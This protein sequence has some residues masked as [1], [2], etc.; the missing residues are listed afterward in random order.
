MLLH[1]GCCWSPDCTDEGEGCT[2]TRSSDNICEALSGSEL[3]LVEATT[4]TSITCN[5]D[6]LQCV[7]GVLT[8]VDVVRGNASVGDEIPY[9]L[10]IEVNGQHNA[11]W[12]CRPGASDSGGAVPLDAASV[13]GSRWWKSPSA[14]VWADG[15]LICFDSQCQIG[16]TYSSAQIEAAARSEPCELATSDGGGC[17]VAAASRRREGSLAWLALVAVGG[18]L[19]QCGRRRP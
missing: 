9:S 2:K 4:A 12:W 19:L 15:E 17:F 16:G 7:E 14:L 8:I 3:W 10:R 13:L 11:F 18:L 5:S 6:G 1:A